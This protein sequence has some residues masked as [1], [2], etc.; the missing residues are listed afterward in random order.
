MTIDDLDTEQWL[1]ATYASLVTAERL[2]RL[3][4]IS[5]TSHGA[6]DAGSPQHRRLPRNTLN[7]VG[8]GLDVGALVAVVMAGSFGAAAGSDKRRR[9]RQTQGTNLYWDDRQGARTCRRPMVED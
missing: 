6:E 7:T 2:R 3:M 5:T 4:H 8:V 1:A 9:S